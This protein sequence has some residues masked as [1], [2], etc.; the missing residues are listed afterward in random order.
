MTKTAAIYARVSTVDQGQDGTSLDTQVERCLEYAQKH[1]YN[2]PD[3]YIAKEMFSGL[4]TKRPKLQEVLEW[5]KGNNVGIIQYQIGI[6]CIEH[7]F[8]S[9]R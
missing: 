7:R 4:T 9:L 6:S 5:I 2:V 3:E 8:L 1:G